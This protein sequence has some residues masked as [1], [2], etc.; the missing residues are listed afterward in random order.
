MKRFTAA[1]LFLVLVSLTTADAAKPGFLARR[2]TE[3]LMDGKPF[4]CV[5]VNKFDLALQFLRGGEEREKAVQAIHEIRAHGFRAVRFGAIG[6]Y[7]KDM[8]LW[9][10]DEYWK[11]MD[12]LVS[13]AKGAGLKLIPVLVW[14]TY[15][16]PDMANETVQDMMT[17][18]DSR[19]RQ[20][21]DLY[22]Y[23][24]VTRYKDEPTILFWDLWSELNLGADLEFMRPYGFSDLNPVQLGAARTRLRRDNYTTKQ[25]IPFLR[26]LAM[27]VKAHDPNHLISSGHACP[28]PASQHLRV[29]EGRGDWTEDSQAE[30]ET[31][32]RNTH[33]DPIDIISIHFYS[34]IDNLRF[35]NRDLRS[36]APLRTLKAI[37]DRIGKPVYIG[38]T[39]G[40]GFISG[41]PVFSRNVL[42]EAVA[43]LY[44]ITMYWMAV[45]D[46]PLDFDL[47]KTT[48][49]NRML[50][51]AEG[52]MR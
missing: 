11:R 20:F 2:G 41:D 4:R 27:L 47:S 43:A 21:V 8:D 19:S 7:P 33:P 42:N 23:Q 34:R 16:F 45:S 32:I 36:A 48:T 29:K 12:D 31:Y 5:S 35:G 40:E 52:R 51:D 13:T 17:N 10:A 15:L 50:T 38:E 14:N 9:P 39:G 18:K 28:R 25:M 30:A 1:I 44:P 49:V 37:C 6:F 26:D 24:M 22:F 46:T 3:L